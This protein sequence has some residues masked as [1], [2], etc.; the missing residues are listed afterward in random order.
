MDEPTLVVHLYPEGQEVDR[1]IVEDGVKVTLGPWESNGL[2]ED[3]FFWPA[4]STWNKVQDARILVYL[5]QQHDGMMILMCPG[6]GYGSSLTT[7]S[8]GLYAAKELTRLGHPVALLLY[9]MP[10]GHHM[11]PLRDAQNA[12]RYLR[13]H[14]SEWGVRQIG[15]MGGSAG[16]HLAACVS[17]MWEDQITRPDFTILDYAVVS[18]TGEL[19]HRGSCRRL[20]GGEDLELMERYSP[21]MHIGP[22]TPPAL[23]FHSADDKAVKPE[24]S[25]AYYQALRAA[26]VRA[27][28]HI[29]PYGG[30]GWAFMSYRISA[31]GD[32]L[33]PYR[34]IYTGTLDTFITDMR[35][36]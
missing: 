18:F 16:G 35:E 31:K 36:R 23:L 26:G 20:T 3:E 28:L 19:T 2:T 27:E 1:G 12:M 32:P 5:P 25:I 24:H 13:Y 9:R 17:T 10:C 33:G 4:D 7:R 11:I 6:G 22:D 34:D 15:V 29:F 30:H 21:C 8:E 14:A